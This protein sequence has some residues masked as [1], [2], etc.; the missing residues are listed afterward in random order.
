MAPD[1][2]YE[3]SVSLPIG[4]DKLVLFTQH[5]DPLHAYDVSPTPT[6]GDLFKVLYIDGQTTIAVP[7]LTLLLD[8]I[9]EKGINLAAEVRGKEDDVATI[10]NRFLDMGRIIRPVW[11][12]EPF[13]ERYGISLADYRPR[14]EG[15]ELRFLTLRTGLLDDP[16]ASLT[17]V[18]L[19]LKTMSY[20]IQVGAHARTR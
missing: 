11:L 10:V 1:A 7:R 5:L 20:T 4:Q 13:E 6:P 8:V 12:Y 15:D 18:S 14:V 9:K 16:D 17:E 2:A 3:Q 19:D